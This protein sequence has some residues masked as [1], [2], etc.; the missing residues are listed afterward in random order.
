MI[1]QIIIFIVSFSTLSFEV[2]LIRLFSITQWNHLSFMV[3]SIALF[4]FT[5]SGIVINITASKIKIVQGHLKEILFLFSF[6]MLISYLY[7]NNIPLDFFKISTDISQL[8]FLS[9]SFIVLSLPFFGSGLITATAFSLMPEKSGSIYFATMFG[10]ACGALFPLVALFFLNVEITIL[11]SIFIP[12][13]FLVFNISANKLLRAGSAILIIVSLLLY[14]FCSNA[15]TIEPSPYKLLSQYKQISNF[16]IIK[17]F[18]TQRARIT[19]I[20]SPYIRNAPGLSLQFK[21][22]L[23]EQSS[24]ITDGD[25]STTLYHEKADGNNFVYYTLPYIGYYLL[26]EESMS[27]NILIIQKGGGTGLYSAINTKGINTITLLEEYPYIADTFKLHYSNPGLN[28]VT[29]NAR[30]FLGGSNDNYDFI[31]IE[32][33]GSSLP[34]MLSLNEEYLLTEEAFLSYLNRL[35]ENGFLIISRKILMPPSDSLKLI[36]TI[37]Q[38]FIKAG[39]NSLKNN[40]I[41]LRS[42]DCFTIL[43]FKSA[44][45]G[46]QLNTVIDFTENLNFDTVYYPGIT[47]ENANKYNIFEFPLYY[48]AINELLNDEDFTS[49]Y[50]LNIIP[51]ADDAPYHNSYIKWD[52]IGELLEDSS[53]RFFSIILSG[54]MILMIIFLSAAV[55]CIL[56]LI[57]PLILSAGNKTKL[58]AYFLFIGA[59]F[60]FMEMAYLKKYTFL[61]GDPVIAFGIVLA[62]LLFFSG[63]GGRFSGSLKIGTLK[64]ILI[65]AVIF[66]GFLFLNIN[67]IVEYLMTLNIIIRTGLSIIIL[68]ATSF[69]IGFPFPAAVRLLLKSPPEIAYGWA[70][71]GGTSVLTSI[72]CIFIAMNTGISV[73]FLFCAVSYF[74]A[75]L[76]ILCYRS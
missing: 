73:L 76:C 21:G 59:G 11:L 52:R 29:E 37:Q 34:G 55:I 2:L 65:G 39:Y 9:L 53:N 5:A 49:N 24:I 46:K 41:V 58:V 22:L 16:E 68:A 64:R 35:T 32:N 8:I 63:L 60:M 14:V 51:Q 40:L 33:W 44:V 43:V 6:T 30:T 45:S 12:L 25:S 3:I 7:I 72:F 27:N 28:I 71:N 42:W 54:E 56:L 62:V 10:S 18:D 75:F 74:I 67:L 23:P 38:A 13:I 48:H 61:Y 66:S 26:S 69:F 70:A 19:H 20:K 15:I 50:I 57:I 31:Q 4:G 47:L 1:S 17:S 36:N